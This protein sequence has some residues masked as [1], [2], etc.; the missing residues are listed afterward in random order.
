MADLTQTIT[1]SIDLLGPSPASE[2]GV[3]LWGT[4]LWGATNDMEFEIG[5][6]LAETANLSDT[7]SFGLAHII[8]H[9]LSVVSSIDLIALTDGSGYTYLL[10]G[11]SDPDNRVFP[12]YTEQTGTDP[13]YT[14]STGT[15]PGWGAA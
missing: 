11:E 13:G 4:G 14:A 10:K 9:N 12:D 7:Y 1:N 5:K 2:W 8:S 15:D 6:W 3:M